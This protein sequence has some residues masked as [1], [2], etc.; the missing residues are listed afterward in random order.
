MTCARWVLMGL[1]VISLLTGP[2]YPTCYWATGQGPGQS[3]E[4][5]APKS[6]WPCLVLGR[7]SVSG[8]LVT[9][10]AA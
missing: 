1:T 3:E 2:G 8:R 7:V 5:S 4:L 10:M 9:I 6:T